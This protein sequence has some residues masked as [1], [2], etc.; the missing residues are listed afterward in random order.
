MP[1]TEQARSNLAKIRSKR[2]Q[3]AKISVCLEPQ[4]YVELDAARSGDDPEILLGIQ[5]QIEEATETFELTS[6]G[7]KFYDEL[8][9]AH[10]PTEEQNAEVRAEAGVDAPYNIDTFAPALVAASLAATEHSPY[11]EED[12]W[13][14]L[15]EELIPEVTAWVD[16]WNVSEF[17]PVWTTAIAVNNAT[18]TRLVGKASG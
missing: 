2:P 14:A 12:A 8:T 18:Q 9:L 15:T 10:T 3:S 1:T 6:I 13:R 4:L 16:E 17:L 7:R 11:R 5:R